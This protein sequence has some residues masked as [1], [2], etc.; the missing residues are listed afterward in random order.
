MTTQQTGHRVHGRRSIDEPV[1]PS[2]MRDPGYSF[3]VQELRDDRRRERRLA[4]KGLI[5]LA[6]VIGFV[7]IREVLL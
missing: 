3:L 5:A 2:D 6:V 4:W 1:V 7:V